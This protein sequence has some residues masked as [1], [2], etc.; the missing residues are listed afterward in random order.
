[1]NTN[2]NDLGS[3][4]EP[5]LNSLFMKHYNNYDKDQSYKKLATII[6]SQSDREEYAWLNNSPTVREFLGERE[7]R[8][9]SD[10]SYTLQNKTWEAT[11]GVDRTTFEDEKFGALQIRVER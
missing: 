9:I 7:I 5:G 8:A 3:L 2:K 4:I 6:Q 10:S 11:L 1:M